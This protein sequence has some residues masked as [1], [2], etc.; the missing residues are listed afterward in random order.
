VTAV[1]FAAYL[2]RLDADTGALR[3]LPGSHRQPFHEGA[4]RRSTAR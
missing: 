1:K 4:F 2:E 3:L